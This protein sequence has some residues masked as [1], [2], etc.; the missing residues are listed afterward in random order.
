MIEAMACGTPVLAFRHGSVPEV[1]DDG[2]TGRIVGS[3][4]EALEALPTVL[5]LDRRAVRARFEERFSVS[6][7]AR[8]YVRL[9]QQQIDL[10]DAARTGEQIRIEAERAISSIVPMPDMAAR[11]MMSGGAKHRGS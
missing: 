1:I 4:E 7:M 5:S 8:D 9:Y 11:A 10:G 2:V 3:M 6:R